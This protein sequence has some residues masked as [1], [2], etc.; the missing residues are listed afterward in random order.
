MYNE[1]N[2]PQNVNF[3]LRYTNQPIYYCE[4]FGPPLCTCKTSTI[5][6]IAAK[7]LAQWAEDVE[8]S[9]LDRAEFQRILD[10]YF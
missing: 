7:N 6:S 8:Q 3:C 10:A 1:N 5:K 9:F 4:I 2:L